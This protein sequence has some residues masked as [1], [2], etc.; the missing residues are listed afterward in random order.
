MK[1]GLVSLVAFGVA[2]AFLYV[3]FQ[4]RMSGG[5]S[6]PAPEGGIPGLLG[7]RLVGADGQ[8]VDTSEL[9][10]KT[11]ALYFSASW[12]GPCRQFTP[13]L[14]R[15]YRELK[16]AGRPFEVVLVSSD[17]DEA[18]MREYMRTASMPWLAVPYDRGRLQAI[19]SRYNVRGIPAVVVLDLDG[20]T[21]STNGRME[22][23]RRGAGAWDLWRS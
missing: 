15:T 23:G 14:V 4:G 6:G 12:C 5:A 21:V 11:V 13:D 3:A 20:R 10:G 2:G 1:N 19:A 7:P 18:A 22:V 17:R 16:A 9:E 8:L